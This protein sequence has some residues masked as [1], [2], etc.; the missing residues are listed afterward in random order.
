M[1]RNRTV[2]RLASRLQS[3]VLSKQV[4]AARSGQESIFDIRSE[5]RFPLPRLREVAAPQ[6]HRLS[7]PQLLAL[8]DAAF[9]NAAYRAVLDRDPDNAGAISYLRALRSGALGKKQLLAVLRYSKEGR[10]KDSKLGGLSWSRAALAIGKIPVLGYLLRMLASIARLPRLAQDAQA[11]DSTVAARF[12]ELTRQCN[13]M[14]EAVEHRFK[15]LDEDLKRVLQIASAQDEV[16]ESQS[17]EALVEL[18]TELEAKR[19]AVAGEFKTFRSTLQNALQRIERNI[20][21]KASTQ[22]LVAGT[23]ELYASFEENF[24]GSTELIRDRQRAYLEHISAVAD[25][26]IALDIGPGRG[27][28]LELLRENGWKGTGL[29]INPIFVAQSLDRGLDVRLEEAVDGLRKFPEG[30]FSLVSAFH[31][32]EHLEFAQLLAL[33][34]EARRVLRPGGMLIL[35]TPNPENLIT[36]S[37]NFYLDPTHRNPIPPAL[38]IFLVTARGFERAEVLRL[39][40][41]PDPQWKSLNDP[42]RQLLSGP[43]DYAVIARRP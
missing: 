13:T 43:Q 20:G 26:A 22:L 39:H 8:S 19:A 14:I 36:A 32:I 23:D 3:V 10:E 35:E 34:D 27:E 38:A 24:R 30:T 28:W 33:L 41:D 25:P 17:R 15:F 1:E 29:E 16:V 21:I 31:V 9:L 18:R 4:S 37:C 2:E 12:D 11:F 42:I 5:T 40:S 7:L 6:K